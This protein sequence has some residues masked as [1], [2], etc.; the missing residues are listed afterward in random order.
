VHGGRFPL[1]FAPDPADPLGAGIDVF[2]LLLE[3]AGSTTKS[4]SKH[5]IWGFVNVMY[6][7]LREMMDQNGPLYGACLLDPKAA[8][9]ESDLELKQLMKGQLVAFALATA[10]EFATRQTQKKD[11]DRIIGLGV[12]G[13]TKLQFTGPWNRMDFDNDGRPIFRFKTSHSPTY[14]LYFRQRALDGRG[15]WVIDDVI[16]PWGAVFAEST[17]PLLKSM[18]TSSP[19]WELNPSFRIDK[20][21]DKSAYRGECLKISGSGKQDGLYLRQPPFDDI[22]GFPHYICQRPGP[23]DSAERRHLFWNTVR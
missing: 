2:A 11:P 3:A 12:S 21:A 10:R 6:W 13:L 15:K 22:A 1:D 9:A 20:V 18:W 17:G 5:S 8:D 4:M 14:Y 19:E 23:I 7:Q 16:D